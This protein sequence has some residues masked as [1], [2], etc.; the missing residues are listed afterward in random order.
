MFNAAMD[1]VAA[2]FNTVQPVVYGGT[3]GADAATAR[4]NL[5]IGA[6]STT[7]AGIIEIAT[8][9]EA[10]TMTDTT[11]AL[12]SDG[13]FFLGGYATTAT[14]AG[15]T[16]LTVT[17]VYDQTFT[18]STTQTVVLP[19]TSTLVLGRRFLITNNSTGAITVQSSGTN[20]ILVLQAG[21]QVEFRCILT[22][23]TT[24]ASW[25]Y[26]SNAIIVPSASLTGTSIDVTGIE[27]WIT[28]IVFSFSL[29][30]I[31]ATGIPTLQIGDS[32]GI[33]TTGYNGATGDVGGPANYTV[34][35][36]LTNGVIA[37]SVYNGA[38]VLTLMSAATNTWSFT[39][40]AGLSSA[41]GNAFGGG[42]KSL[43]APLD[44]FRIT[45]VAGSA[46]YDAGTYGYRRS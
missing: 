9:T 8:P 15:T 33:E 21:A 13:L 42:T 44:R 46:S 24:A 6:A 36:D 41:A 34:G 4:T 16:T 1:D 28:Q 17:S 12:A 27:P 10:S 37:S 25:D 35:F 18:G 7:A 2:A 31:N 38:A 19:V 3:G 30:S 20:T 11:R 29:L 23:G 43:S 14:A 40:V 39:T 26:R 22:S 45:T 5:G 32:G